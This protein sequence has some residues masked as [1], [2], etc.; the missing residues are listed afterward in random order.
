M[1]V[2]ISRHHLALL[3][4][5]VDRAEPSSMSDPTSTAPAG[6]PVDAVLSMQATLDK[7]DRVRVFNIALTRE[8]GTNDAC[9]SPAGK[10][11]FYADADDAKAALSEL[12]ALLPHAKLR[13]ETIPLGRAFALTQGLMG[14]RSPVPCQIQFSRS[15]TLQ[16]GENGV[17][18]ELRE[19]MRSAGPFPLFFLPGLGAPVVTPVFFAREDLAECW[20]KKSGR[21]LAELPE[22]SVTDLRILIARTLQEPGQWTPLVYMP[23]KAAVLLAKQIET[24]AIHQCSARRFEL[25]TIL[26]LTVLSPLCPL[27]GP[28]FAL[29]CEQE[30]DSIGVY[31]RSG[32]A[33]ARGAC[34]RPGRRRLPTTSR[35]RWSGH[36]MLLCG[37]PSRR[38][39]LVFGLA[40]R[41]VHE[42]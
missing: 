29:P 21:P 6:Q 33:A 10:L 42:R 40:S 26:I 17:P 13:L 37:L 32:E 18:E 23:S 20:A 2:V 1:Y 38:P 24:Q 36:L 35:G 30:V 16:E 15:V 39:R 12:Q 11:T 28:A 9:P 19:K 25:S 34:G 22:V 8:D 3:T 41:F 4:K 27:T 5:A 7:L 14:L 31:A